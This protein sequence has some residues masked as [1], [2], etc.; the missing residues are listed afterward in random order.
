VKR[1]KETIADLHKTSQQSKLALDLA[2]LEDDVD[3]CSIPIG[4]FKSKIMRD[5]HK[6]LCKKPKHWS[7]TTK[8]SKK[9]MWSKVAQSAAGGRH[10]L[11]NDTQKAGK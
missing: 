4:D 1:F 2:L 7:T 8:K 6:K 3:M 10:K 9:S 11:Y 5:R